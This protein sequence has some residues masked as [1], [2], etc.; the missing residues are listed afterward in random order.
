MTGYAHIFAL[1]SSTGD[2]GQVEV[3]RYQFT[4][5][6]GGNAYSKVLAE[7]ELQE[8]LLDELGLR[9]DLV[10]QTL[11]IVR[12]EGKVT[13]PDVEISENDAAVMGMMVAGTDY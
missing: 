1:P 11:K 9:A 5:D 4:F 7:G 13:I 8:F 3:P 10:D 2:S 6:V 12:D